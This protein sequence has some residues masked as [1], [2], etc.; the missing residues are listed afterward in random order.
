MAPAILPFLHQQD[1]N[2]KIVVPFQTHGGWLGN[3]LAD[4]AAVCRGVKVT[5][6]RQVKFGS[7]SGDPME[8]PE[9]EV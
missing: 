1:W 7:T 9:T 3:V 5:C 4:I 2:G 8:T 6:D